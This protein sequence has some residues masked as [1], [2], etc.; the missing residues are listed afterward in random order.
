MLTYKEAREFV[1][2]T[3]SRGSVLGL[4]NM[5]ALME[6]LG[7]PQNSIR[8]IHI[9]GTNGKGSVGAYLAS[10][11]KEAHFT[12]G[13]F[14][15]PAVFHELECWQYDGRNI[16]EEEY[17]D[18]MSQVKKAC[19][20][21]M[22]KDIYPTSFEVETA[23]AFVYF[24]KLQP[25]VFILETGMGGET[26]ATN[27][28]DNPL[29]CVFTK[30]SRDHM[31]FL[32]ESLEE[33]AKVKAGIMKPGA[34][35][36]WGEQEPEVERVL[37]AK[38]DEVLEVGKQTANEPILGD[39]YTSR[40]KLI[41]Q[42]V[43]ELRFSYLG[44]NY[45]TRM[46]GLYQMQNATLAIAVFD[47][48]WPKL[49]FNLQDEMEMWND[50]DAPI[51]GWMDMEYASRAGVL[52]ANWP[53]R[54]EELG[55]N[56]LFILD[57]AHNEDA[58]R[59]LAKTIENCFT[60]QSLVYIIGVLADKEHKK[61]LEIMLPYAA[62]VYTITPPNTRGLDGMALAEE[63]KTVSVG[64]GKT[65]EVQYCDSINQA[66]EGAKA[67]GLEHNMPVLAFGSLSYLGRLKQVYLDARL[68]Q[69]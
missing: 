10:I 9:A 39:V 24:A 25:D 65:I 53:G 41:S 7:N 8:T 46:T 68:E 12:V 19:D 3:K 20:I 2:E 69:Y 66:V 1:E 61:M 60:N 21:V 43:G 32:G 48:I 42:S 5:R 59:E 54:F 44:V 17:A 22:S 67:Y 28:V 16:T 50:E 37:E 51:A 56:P 55:N 58:A 11:C 40:T 57:G 29:A 34:M 26:D 13:R 33:I 18:A 62:K 49:L 6:E 64:L 45:M 31:Q 14:C 4:T 47:G 15:S 23:M 38:F 52:F 63:V 27:V 30:I 35:I 36:F